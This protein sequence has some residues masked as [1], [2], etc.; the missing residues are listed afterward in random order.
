MKQNKLIVFVGIGFELVGTMVVCIYAGLWVDERY[1][2]NGL[3]IGLF[4]MLGLAGWIYRVVLLTKR[5]EKS[6]E[7]Q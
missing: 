7:E 5:M 6:E 1:G 4:P 3:G 2:T